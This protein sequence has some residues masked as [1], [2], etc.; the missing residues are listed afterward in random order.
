MTNKRVWLL[1]VIGLCLL[2]LTPPGVIAQTTTEQTT[3]YYEEDETPDE[4]LGCAICAGMVGIP[5]V[6]YLIIS[7]GI[8]WWI[9]RDA[10][11]RANP[12]AAIWALL[13]FL[14]N[15]LGLIIYLIVRS[16]PTTPPPVAPPPPPP[17]I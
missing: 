10:K 14:F 17:S 4:A 5:V 1:L 9:Y 15:L 16:R 13:G 8:A 12:Q 7:I 11:S 3:T 2:V 6:L